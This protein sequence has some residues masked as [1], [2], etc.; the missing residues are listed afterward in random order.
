[1]ED[2]CEGEKGMRATE[3]CEVALKPWGMVFSVRLEI[4]D[5]VC[6]FS[7]GSKKSTSPQPMKMNFLPRE[8]SK[9]G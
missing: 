6:F 5:P 1:M 2:E 4:K 3:R 8:L 9:T 7:L